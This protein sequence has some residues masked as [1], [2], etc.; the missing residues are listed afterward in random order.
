MSASDQSVVIVRTYDH[1]GHKNLP[2]ACPQW[3]D[4]EVAGRVRMLMRNDLD[5]EMIC[6]VA[7][8]RILCLAKEKARYAQLLY[9]AKHLVLAATGPDGGPTDWNE[10]RDRWLELLDED[11]IGSSR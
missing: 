1:N 3:D 11:G 8:D 2:I 4:V 5:H 10:T 7:R 6:T 9:A